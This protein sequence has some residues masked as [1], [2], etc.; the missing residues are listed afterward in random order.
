MCLFVFS[1]CLLLVTAQKKRLDFIEYDDIRREFFAVSRIH[2]V[3][4]DGVNVCGKI[5]RNGLDKTDKA[6]KT[7][8]L[9]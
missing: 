8:G 6:L 2:Y 9:V 1:S 5:T 7:L 4:E 3:K